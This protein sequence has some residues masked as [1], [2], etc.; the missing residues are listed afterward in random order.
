[1]LC[2]FLLNPFGSYLLLV[3]VCLSLVSVSM[4]CPLLRLECWSLPLFLYEVQCVLWALVKFLLWMRVPL[5]LEHSCSELR[6]HLGI[7]FSLTRMKCPFFNI[8]FCWKSIVFDIRMA[9]P[10]F[11]LWPSAWKLFFSS[12]L[13][14]SVWLCHWSMFSVCRKMLG[15][16]YTSSLLVYVF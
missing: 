13:C 10:A 1:M 8:T 11:F 2:R 16:V 3:S 15:P 7:Y 12:L 9:T 5:F 4:I 14:S 6:V